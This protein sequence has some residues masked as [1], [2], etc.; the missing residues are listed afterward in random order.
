MV[1][2]QMLGPLIVMFL[3]P[4]LAPANLIWPITALFLAAGL[5]VLGNG[6]QRSYPVCKIEKEGKDVA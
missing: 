5:L 1:V 2:G 4:V 3:M 6:M